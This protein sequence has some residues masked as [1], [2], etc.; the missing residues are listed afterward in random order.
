MIAL[1]LAFFGRE[2]NAQTRAAAAD[3]SAAIG[4]PQTRSL[5]LLRELDSSLVSLTEKVTPAVV[6]ITVTSYGP[7]DT[8][9]QTTDLSLVAR[10]H[11]IGSGV[12]VDSNGYIITNDHVVDGAQRIRVALSPG[13]S[14][15]FHA[16]NPE[17]HR[18]FDA[19]L[20]GSDKDTD[21]AVLKIDAHGLPMLALADTRPVHSGELVLAVGSPQGLQSSVTMGVV[22]AVSRQASTDEP[23]VFIQTDAPINPGSSGGPLIDIDGY[24]IGLNTMIMT[25]RGG[26][27]GLGFAIPANTVQFVYENLRKYGHVHRTELQVS[28]QEITPTLSEGL[29]LSQD[30]G[31]VISDVGET[32]PAD[33][34]GV[35]IGDIVLSV[36]GR[37]I[38]GLPDFST[39][40]YLH[41]PRQPVRLDVLRGKQ[42]MSLTVPAVQHDDSP[43]DLADLIK[44]ED[45]VGRLGVFVRDF[46]QSVR[47]VLGDNVRIASGVVVVAQS[48]E[49][50]SYTSS[51]HAGD[52]VHAVNSKPV[53]SVNQ[54]RNFLDGLK[55]GQSVALQVERGGRLQYV[56]FEWGD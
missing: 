53:R 22:S 3:L 25:D 1:L 10:Q 5:S 20:V 48:P 34:A 44:P 52:I 23:A 28:A 32:G 9:S 39:A 51:L 42:K 27:V 14:A 6:Q 55:T 31:V 11:R 50:N 33:A 8:D 21:L 4:H 56:S 45:L 41:S 29:A 54:L 49:L 26:S 18:V 19:K 36:D 7:V 13:S 30:W 37:V 43:E 40:L 12:I 15:P 38:T 16:P 17:Q 35:K 2:L 24:V 47:D 46:D